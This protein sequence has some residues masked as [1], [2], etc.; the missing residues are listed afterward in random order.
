L[1]KKLIIWGATGQ[2]IVLEEFLSADYE[3]VALFDKNEKVISPFSN[4]KIYHHEEE[5]K[6]YCKSIKQLHFIVAIGGNNG[7]ERLSISNK[8]VDWGLIPI[9]AIHPKSSIATNASIGIGSQILIGSCIA[10]KAT[11]GDYCI[12]N[13]GASIDHECILKNGVHVAPNATLAGCI[14]VDEYAFIGSNATILPKIKIGKNAV[15]GAG[16]VVTKNVDDNT[17]VVGVP[18]NKIK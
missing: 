15:I 6:D 8:L 2:S 7:L 17:T 11:I 3:I 16:A 10:A 18:A 1:K 9:S 13:T 14:Q 5:F 12:I 4:I